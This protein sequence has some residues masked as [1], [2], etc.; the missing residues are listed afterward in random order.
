MP[1]KKA[2][3]TRDLTGFASRAK[4]IL[5]RQDGKDKKSYESWKARVEELSSKDGGGLTKNEAVVRASKEYPCLGKIFR[6]FDVREFDAN[7]ESHA[8][9]RHYGE[10]PPKAGQVRCEG[11]E[12]SYRENLRWAMN[13]AGEH[14]RTG[15]APTSCPNNSAFYFYEQAR[16]E[17]KDFLAKVGQIESK[18]DGESEAQKNARLAGKRS[19]TEIDGMLSELEIEPEEERV[20]DAS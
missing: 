7:P 3:K 5:W 11:K 18:S 6:E 1:A 4:S 16:S 8:H 15:E 19:I 14:V 13:A 12:Q 9:I 10:A 2:S 20:E 17:P